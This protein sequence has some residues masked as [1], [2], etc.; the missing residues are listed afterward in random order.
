[1][2]EQSPNGIQIAKV[3]S[4]QENTSMKKMVLGTTAYVLVSFI[5]QAASHFAINQSHYASIPF[6]R[7]EPILWMGV[8]TLVIQGAILSHLYTYYAKGD[9]TI[10][11]GWMFGLMAGL[12]LLLYI[13]LVEPSKYEVP[14]VSSWIVVEGIAGFVQFSVFGIFLG[15]MNKTTKAD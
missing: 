14:S 6:I 4:D 5:V 15:L 7:Q 10:K 12:I 3:L 13:A 9:S 1:M 8:L 11:K 2:E